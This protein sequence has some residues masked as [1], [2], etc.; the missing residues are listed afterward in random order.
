MQTKR[1]LRPACH[2]LELQLNKDLDVFVA[3]YHKVFIK[4]NE[5]S[6]KLFMSH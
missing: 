2:K 3:N 1:C 6:G 5:D 4:E